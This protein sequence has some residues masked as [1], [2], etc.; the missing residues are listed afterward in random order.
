MMVIW[1]RVCTDSI[2]WDAARATIL[3]AED[4]VQPIRH[5]DSSRMT[6]YG[7]ARLRYVIMYVLA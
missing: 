6:E 7:Q 4:R 2:D 3:D 5:R 1:A